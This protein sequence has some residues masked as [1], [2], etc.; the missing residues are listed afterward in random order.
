MAFQLMATSKQTD[1]DSRIRVMVVDDSAVARGLIKKALDDDPGVTVVA[2]AH[3]GEQALRDLARNDIDVIVLD[4]DMPVMDGLTALPKL[5]EAKP[6]VKI[7]MASALTAT[8]AEIS[9]RALELGAADY[10][11]KPSTNR[12]ITS[13]SDFRTDLLMRVKALGATAPGRQSMFSA[14]ARRAKPRSAYREALAA[15]DPSGVATPMFLPSGKVVLRA[16]GRHRPGVLAVGA[17]T[18]GPQA[19][20][21]FFGDLDR[22]IPVPV[23]LT[24][25]MP[26]TFTAILAEHI[27]RVTGWPCAEAQ[28][29]DVLQPGRIYLAPGGYHMTVRATGTDRRIAL[30]QDA[31]ENFCRPAVD[32]MLRSLVSV[33]GPAIVTVILT[34]MGVDGLRGCERVVEAGGTVFAQ[35]RGSSVVWG[36]PGAV[37]TGGLCTDVLPIASLGGAVGTFVQKAV[38]K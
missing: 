33:Y 4:I 2:T 37:A 35:D 7:I 29:G 13:G 34:G 26:P 10:I 28:D 14:E 23:V 3:N 38:A 22:S 20:F 17:S 1:P 6:D 16:P 21:R 5:I 8:N 31:L 9:L 30:N 32:P 24:Q 36:M 27:A 25:H 18:G 12:E 11:P 15:A 19:L